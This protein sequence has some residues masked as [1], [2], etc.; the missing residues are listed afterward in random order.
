MLILLLLFVNWSL[1][2]TVKLSLKRFILCRGMAKD[3]LWKTRSR[4]PGFEPLASDARIQKLVERV[5]VA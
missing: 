2:R 1:L 4:A 5:F 3:I